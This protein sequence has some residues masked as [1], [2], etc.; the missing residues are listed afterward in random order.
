MFIEGSG[1]LYLN[2]LMMYNKN[3]VSWFIKA[4]DTFGCLSNMFQKDLENKL[5]V[6]GLEYRSSEALY[7]ACRFPN[8]PVVQEKIR[9]QT[10]PMA[11]KMVSKPHR[12]DKCRD[13]WDGVRLDI[14]RWVLRVKL[15][16]NL[17][18]MGA[19]L[20]LTKDTDIVEISTKRDQ[21]WGTVDDGDGNLTGANMMGVLLME[22]RKEYVEKGDGMKEVNYPNELNLNLQKA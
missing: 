16:C 6:N 2:N 12:D 20:K 22:L 3:E 9:L 5:I 15:S 21:F 10:S 4:S 13:D 18:Q 7:Q 8:H 17:D 19:F 1:V 11:A 14:M